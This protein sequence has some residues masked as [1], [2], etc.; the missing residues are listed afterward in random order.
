M[1]LS[2]CGPNRLKYGLL[3]SVSQ[4]AM[5][6]FEAVSNGRRIDC[7]AAVFIVWGSAPLAPPPAAPGGPV[8]QWLEPAAHNGL[9]AGSSPAGPTTQFKG[10]ASHPKFGAVIHSQIVCDLKLFGR[11]IISLT[12]PLFTDRRTAFGFPELQ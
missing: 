2:Q 12:S 3:G 5:P 7:G 6:W 4:Q 8:A 9:V 11:K 1:G 10:S